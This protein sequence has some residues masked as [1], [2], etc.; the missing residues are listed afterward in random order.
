MCVYVYNFPK[1]TDQS[2][3]VAVLLHGWTFGSFLSAT[4]TRPV[5]E[6]REGTKSSASQTEHRVVAFELL[7]DFI[8]LQYSVTE[9]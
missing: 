7:V 8:Q 5:P 1:S 2:Y 9:G 6:I 3:G 4:T